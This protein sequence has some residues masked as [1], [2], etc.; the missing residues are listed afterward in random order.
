M[1]DI[2]NFALKDADPAVKGCLCVCWTVAALCFVVSS[3]TGN[4]SQVDKLWSIL[5]CVYAWILLK[6]T[7]TAVMAGLVTLWGMRLSYNFYRRG[8]YTFPKVWCGEEDY[9]WPALRSGSIPQLSF[10]KHPL[11]WTLFNL[12]FISTYQNFLL[13]AIVSPS[14]VA[15]SV[16]TSAATKTPWNV[17]DS[18][19]ASFFLFFLLLETIADNQQWAF[20]TEKDR[21]RRLKEEL[22][23]DFKDGFLHTAGLYL[24]VRKPNYAAE[25]ALWI[26]YY[27]FSVGASRGRHN[28]SILGC[29]LLVLLFQGSGWL[30]ELLTTQKYP[31]YDEYKKQVPRYFPSIL[32]LLLRCCN[33]EPIKQL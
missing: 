4:V 26:S 25:Q 29:T 6:D 16:A 11:V 1:W 8:G 12:L 33:G 10:L 21:K 30:T 24:F 20:Q 18:L 23:G 13:L 19:A 31:K 27:W 5:P 17:W 32:R 2:C 14:I 28:W 15:S 22:V 9:R 3:L 7:R